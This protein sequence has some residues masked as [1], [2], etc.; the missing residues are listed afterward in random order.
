MNTEQETNIRMEESELNLGEMLQTGWANWYWFVLSVVVCAGAAFLYLK[1]A[2]KVYTRTAS[3]LIK[4][5]AKGGAMSES[6]AFE[7][8]GLFGSKRNVDNEVLVFKSRR[9]M[10]EVARNLH[11]DVSY[12]VKD[13]LRT[14]ELYTQ[15]PVQLSFPDAE[16]AQA[17]SLKAVPVSGKEVIL[18]GFTLGGQE[19]A[20]GKP[21]KV[22]LNDTVTTPVGRVVVVPSLY[23]GDKYFNTVV[24]VT[25]SPL[26][27]VALRFQGGLQATLANKASTIINLTLQDVSIPRAEDVINTLISVYNT[28]AINDKNQIVMNTSNFINDRLIVIEKELGC[29]FGYRV[30]QAGTPTDGYLVR[31]GHVPADLQPI[32]PGGIESGE[33]V[34]SGEIHQELPD[35]P[36]QEFGPDPGEHGHIGCEHRVADRGVQRDV[37][38]TRQADQQQQ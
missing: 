17:F 13:G 37:A 14:V 7:D 24:Q 11:L 26:Q 35:G 38:E 9:L 28:D 16:E 15:S 3:V 8:L 22:A 30:V 10:T 27:D 32:P 33:P 34:E 20:D 5:D 31:D 12:T 19:V 29:G 18:S 1:W 36:R 21:V 6:A 4:D 25:K 23:Y 2:P